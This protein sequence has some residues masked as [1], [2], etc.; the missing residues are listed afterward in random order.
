[1]KNAKSDQ[2]FLKVNNFENGMRHTLKGFQNKSDFCDVTL[3]CEDGQVEAH[4][5]I[6]SSCSP[7]FD[8]ILVKILTNTL[9]CT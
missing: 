9:S 3:A 7:V 4:K 2:L 8:S 5:L 6:L 1:M